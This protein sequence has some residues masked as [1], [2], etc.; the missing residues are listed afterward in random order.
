MWVFQELEV[1]QQQQGVRLHRSLS[2]DRDAAVDRADQAQTPRHG[3]P[4]VRLPLKLS[5]ILV[6]HQARYRR[7]DTT[8]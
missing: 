3:R 2:A 1:S 6:L 8:V 7:S 5:I 4:E